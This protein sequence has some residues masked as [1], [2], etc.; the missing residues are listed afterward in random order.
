VADALFS[1]AAVGRILNAGTGHDVSVNALAATIERDASRIVHV[2]HI[3][4]QSEIQV[5]RCDPSLARA[6]LGWRPQVKLDDG[7]ARVRAW[8]AERLAAGI[9]VA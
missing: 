3:H 8:M 5:L 9:P 6:V 2:E 4:P 7:L 1:D